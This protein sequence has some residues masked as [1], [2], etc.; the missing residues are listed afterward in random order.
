MFTFLLVGTQH[1]ETN[2]S[3]DTSI[4]FVVVCSGG[5]V[6]LGLVVAGVLVQKRM[7]SETRGRN[8][9]NDIYSSICYRSFI[10]S[11]LPFHRL[12]NITIVIFFLYITL[13]F[14]Y[15]NCQSAIKGM[16]M[17]QKNMR[18]ITPEQKRR[19][20]EPDEEINNK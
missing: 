6:L 16:I 15:T 18:M 1:D 9:G 4:I 20:L 11:Y 3:E 12:R 2:G 19:L 8:V 14:F 10:A 7:K 17:S 5:V 13:F